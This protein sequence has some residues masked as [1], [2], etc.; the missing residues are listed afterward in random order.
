[1]PLDFLAATI[2]RWVGY[3]ALAALIGSLTV[4]LLVL[5]DDAPERPKHRNVTMIPGQG[6]RV[7][8]TAVRR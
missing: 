2:T 8:A 7:I 4:D 5:P 6:G 1:M 3:F